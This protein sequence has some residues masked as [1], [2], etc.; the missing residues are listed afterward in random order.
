MNILFIAYR[1]ISKA[2][3]FSFFTI[4]L[5]VICLSSLKLIGTDDSIFTMSSTIRAYKTISIDVNG[6]GRKDMIEISIDENRKEYMVNITN[7]NG[8]KYQLS[9]AKSESI[10]PYVPW[11]PLR[12]TIADINIDKIPEIILQVSQS[13]QALPL[14]IFRWDG[15]QY[16]NIFSGN[17]DGITIADLN[18]DGIPEIVAEERL[19]GTGYTNSTYSWMVNS[20]RKINTDLISSVRGYDKI[21][22]IIKLLSSPYEEKLPPHDVL[23]RYF[24]DEWLSESKNKD[25]LIN[26][27]K[28]IVGMQLKDY[29]GEEIK[30]YNGKP[31][32]DIWRL[33]Y[34]VFRKFGTDVKLEN[35][36]AE[37][38]TEKTNT[39]EGDY[40]IKKISFS[41]ME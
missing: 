1:K 23:S 11:W 32:A 10:G 25:Y 19:A 28:N 34:M 33:R 39:P 9:G 17:Y 20:Y 4:I 37:I 3:L 7:D 12:I 18:G 16:S 30:E 2:I 24:T 41:A 14:N 26:F 38:I 36:T 40:K 8:K 29:I 6:N 35:Y 31:K 22:S 5:W 27:S 13:T 15:K 21:Q